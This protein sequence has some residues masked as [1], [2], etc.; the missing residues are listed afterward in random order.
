MT[1]QLAG[2]LWRSGQQWV[3]GHPYRK[4][5]HSKP[6]TGVLDAANEEAGSTSP[7]RHR[8][9]TTASPRAS[10]HRA[11]PDRLRCCLR[12]SDQS[13]TSRPSRWSAFRG[14]S[15][16]GHDDAN[17]LMGRTCSARPSASGGRA[18][19]RRNRS[20][21]VVTIRSAWSSRRQG[22]YGHRRRST[23]IILNHNDIYKMRKYVGLNE[24]PA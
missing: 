17:A 5:K 23:R 21:A 12:R 20:G 4:I 2:Y 19:D 8:S 18:A 6:P 1:D 14:Y 13:W 10:A 7:S 9:T 15:V 24:R 11:I 22:W 3:P 16:P